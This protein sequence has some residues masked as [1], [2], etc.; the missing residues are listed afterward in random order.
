M[1]VAIHISGHFLVIYRGLYTLKTVALNSFIHKARRVENVCG[2]AI[3]GG[4]NLAATYAYR[5]VYGQTISIEVAVSDP[6][7]QRLIIRGIQSRYSVVAKIYV[8]RH[9]FHVLA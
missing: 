2:I 5:Y 8:Q 6:F 4:S 9:T 7:V 3:D 1:L